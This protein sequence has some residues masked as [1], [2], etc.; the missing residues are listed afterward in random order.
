MKQNTRYIAAGL[1]IW[2]C[3]AFATGVSGKFHQASA[4]AVAATVW[5]LTGLTLLACWKI[6][7]VRD[8]V[9]NSDLRW[10]I[11]VH[12]TRFVGIYFLVLRACGAL[13]DGF[14][15]PAG[16]GDIAVAGSA[17][18]ILLIPEVL[19]ARTVLLTWNAL[20]LADI[21]F[22]A[23]AALRFGLRD[24]ESMAPLREL[25]L[26]LL[27]TFVVPLII[28]SHVVIFARLAR[29]QMHREGSV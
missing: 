19:A 17:L 4:P 20:G 12:L 23:F 11:A 25:P 6:P 3:L 27:P 13:P 26:S 14:A 28:A 2:L 7:A 1:S 21:V 24:V 8:W 18:L 22:V 10:L 16:I 5:I 29:R 15:R 9:T